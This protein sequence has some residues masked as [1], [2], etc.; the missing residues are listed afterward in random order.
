[1]CNYKLSDKKAPYPR[2]AYDC[3]CGFYYVQMEGYKFGL[4]NERT[5]DLI[6]PNGKCMKCKKEIT[7]NNPS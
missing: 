3:S 1:M 5:S 7:V 4:D 6:S 2:V